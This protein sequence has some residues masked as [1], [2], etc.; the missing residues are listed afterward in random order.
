MNILFYERT[1][2]EKKVLSRSLPKT[3][4]AIILKVFK[5]IKRGAFFKKHPFIYYYLELSSN[6]VLTL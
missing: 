3:F 4:K 6:L 2:F 5:G 1:F